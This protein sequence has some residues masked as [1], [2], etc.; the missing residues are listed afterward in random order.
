[1]LWMCVWGMCVCVLSV[2]SCE[3]P[4]FPCRADGTEMNRAWLFLLM[5]PGPRAHKATRCGGELSLSVWP[6]CSLMSRE[7][8]FITAGGLHIVDK[9]G[10]YSNVSSSTGIFIM[11]LIY[12]PLRTNLALTLF[13]NHG[14]YEM[15][16]IVD[17][18]RPSHRHIQ[19]C[20]W[21]VSEPSVSARIR[22]RWV[23]KPRALGGEL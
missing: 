22:T 18:G 16:F 4:S 3:Q 1:M 10:A 21:G 23:F 6:R 2:L 17:D 20:R 8:P 15:H 12:S 13:S 9:P 14:G 19:S 11:P 7:E 5:S